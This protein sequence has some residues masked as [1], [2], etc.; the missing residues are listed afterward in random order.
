MADFLLE[1]LYTGASDRNIHAGQPIR[2]Q[3]TYCVR[4]GIV[5]V[6]LAVEPRESLILRQSMNALGSIRW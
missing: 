3:V 1:P 5:A 4:V 2:K 6:G